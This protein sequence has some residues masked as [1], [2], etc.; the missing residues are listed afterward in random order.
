MLSNGIHFINQGHGWLIYPAGLIISH[1]L[2]VVRYFSD[3]IGLMYLGRLVEAGPAEEVYLRPA[4]PYTRRLL[5]SAQARRAAGRTRP[6][7]SASISSTEP[8]PAR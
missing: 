8:A 1:D 7:L 5:D 6:S 2:V 3:K 4:H